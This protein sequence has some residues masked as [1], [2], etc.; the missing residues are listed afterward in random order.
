MTSGEILHE[1]KLGFRGF[2]FFLLAWK[3]K[4]YKIQPVQTFIL[5]NTVQMVGSKIIL[6]KLRPD[7]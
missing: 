2:T 3:Q 6:S 1:V 4:D 7:S 5:M